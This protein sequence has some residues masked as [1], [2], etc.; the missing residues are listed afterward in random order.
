MKGPSNTSHYK[1]IIFK[2]IFQIIRLLNIKKIMRK[3]L[4]FMVP[5]LLRI[6][7]FDKTTHLGLF[8]LLGLFNYTSSYSR[9]YLIRKSNISSFN[10]DFD[11]KFYNLK[12]V[13]I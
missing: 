3:L 9:T 6:L 13:R 11:R 2:S 5:T 10:C 8:K 1:K 12:I 7:Q 4:L